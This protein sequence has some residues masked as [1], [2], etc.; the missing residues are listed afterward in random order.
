M[1]DTNDIIEILFNSLQK[2]QEKLEESI[3]RSNLIF[4][5]VDLLY[6]HLHRINLKRGGRLGVSSGGADLTKIIK[7]W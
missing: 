6:Y 4:Y 2:Y 5:S 7:A 3:K 1:Y